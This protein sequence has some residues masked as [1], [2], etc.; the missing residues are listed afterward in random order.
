MLEYWNQAVSHVTGN[1]TRFSIA[2]GRAKYQE[3]FFLLAIVSSFSV[4]SFIT[5]ILTGVTKFKV[6]RRYGMLF[7][8]ESAIL[9]TSAMI[10][11]FER[12]EPWSRWIYCL[13]S[14]ACGIQVCG[15]SANC[16]TPCVLHLVGL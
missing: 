6:S 3:A 15:I 9:F 4:G 7:L 13:L 1:M 14:I 10:L 2:I 16:R 8:V 11:D 5:G 12:K